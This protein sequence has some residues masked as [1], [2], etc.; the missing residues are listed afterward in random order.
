[1]RLT[2]PKQVKNTDYILKFDG[3]LGL[4]DNIFNL[5]KDFP[6]KIKL[7]IHFIPYQPV[8]HFEQIFILL[9]LVTK[10]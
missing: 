2:T 6:F 1:M 3:C 4:V 7:I 9:T 5:M 8:L 10:K